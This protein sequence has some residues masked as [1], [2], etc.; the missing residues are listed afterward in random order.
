MKR[1]GKEL[2][3]EVEKH[4]HFF[5]DEEE[6]GDEVE[7]LAQNEKAPVKDAIEW[8]EVEPER[9]QIWQ[10][11]QV[12]D[13]LI[14]HIIALN[15]GLFGLYAIVKNSA[16]G[17]IQTPAHKLLQSRLRRCKEGDMVKIIYKGQIQVKSGR[18]AANY[19]MYRQ[20]RGVINTKLLFNGCNIKSEEER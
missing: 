16:G 17:E 9:Q 20:R 4:D 14:G 7:E 10:P 18:L 15:E 11:A 3:N 5:I 6:W 2:K 8:E 19:V 13:F 1:E 12:G